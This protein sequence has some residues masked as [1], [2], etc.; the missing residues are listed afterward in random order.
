MRCQLG[1]QIHGD[2]PPSFPEKDSLN[3]IMNEFIVNL[4]YRNKR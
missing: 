3:D 2:K 1:K 4:I